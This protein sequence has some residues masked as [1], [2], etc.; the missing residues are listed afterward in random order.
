MIQN[1]LWLKWY[2]I[3]I[4][5]VPECFTYLAL[6]GIKIGANKAKTKGTEVTKHNNLQSAK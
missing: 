4:K 5:K 6:S 3:F 2:K 1:K